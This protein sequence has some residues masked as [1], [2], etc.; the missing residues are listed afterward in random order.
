[1]KDMKHEYKSFIFL[2]RTCADQVAVKC[3]YHMYRCCYIHSMKPLQTY[4][5]LFGSGPEEKLLWTS[6]NLP[7]LSHTKMTH[8][9]NF[10]DMF[11]LSADEIH[12]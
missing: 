3:G 4:E 6:I 8:L 11:I 10:A 2:S 9:E 5:R 12:R 1:M 7:E